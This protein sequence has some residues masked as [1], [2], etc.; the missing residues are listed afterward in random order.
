MKG[1]ME[2]NF[3]HFVFLMHHADGSIMLRGCFNSRDQKTHEGG[4]KE[5]SYTKMLEDNMLRSVRA[6][7]ASRKV[8]QTDSNFKVSDV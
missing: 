2:L 6:L 4:K 1:T 3:W 7:G 5:R 8:T